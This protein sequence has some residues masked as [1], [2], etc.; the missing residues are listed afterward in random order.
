M[1]R[2][3]L[4]CL[5]LALSGCSGLKPHNDQNTSAAGAPR[6]TSSSDPTIVN[7]GV[8]GV[9]AT[10]GNWNKDDAN[11][12]YRYN[13]T[14]EFGSADPSCGSNYTA[15]SGDPNINNLLQRAYILRTGIKAHIGTGCY[16][17]SVEIGGA[18]FP[19]N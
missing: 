1:K 8:L 10:K 16:L 18:S 17:S 7:T 19:A 14:G 3:I 9:T 2:F 15:A 4:L 12:I 11:N 5:G 6:N 13:F